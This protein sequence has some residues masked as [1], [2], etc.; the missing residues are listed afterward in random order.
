MNN[1]KKKAIWIIGTLLAV[2]AIAIAVVLICNNR[3]FERTTIYPDD[4][5][6]RPSDTTYVVNGVEFKMIGIQ[7]GIFRGE[8]LKDE[9]EL[10]NFYISETEVTRELWYAVMGRDPKL[11][12]DDAQ[13]PVSD[14]S[15]DDC[16]DFLERLDSISDVGFYLPP[17]EYWL[18]AAYFGKSGQEMSD[19]DNSAWHAGNSEGETHSVKL[20]HPD[21]SGLYDMV[22]NVA[23]WT[24]SGPDP[25]FIVAGGSYK[26]DST[27]CSLDSYDI[28][29]ANVR[30]DHIGFRIIH[31]RSD[32]H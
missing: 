3:K 31:I 11:L 17:Y 25:L 4:S 7:G 19:L 27:N 20:K 21:A 1:K 9:V 6:T 32:K 8:G 15:I 29:H 30:L 18:Y 5:L 14:I 10:P 16:F 12:G 2:A 22:G 23:E 28:N 26:D 24:I 13:L